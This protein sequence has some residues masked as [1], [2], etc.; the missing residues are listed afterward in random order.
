MTSQEIWIGLLS[1]LLVNIATGALTYLFTT[2]RDAAR[3]EKEK[4]E[5]DA[6]IAAIAVSQLRST[7]LSTTSLRRDVLGHATDVRTGTVKPE[8]F[9]EILAGIAR[10]L[11][12]DTIAILP[13]MQTWRGFVSE[14]SDTAKILDGMSALAQSDTV[15]GT[16]AGS[17]IQRAKAP[18]ESASPGAALPPVVGPVT[19][20][21]SESKSG[22]AAG[23]GATKRKRSLFTSPIELAAR[24][25]ATGDIQSLVEMKDAL[26]TIPMTP[27][28]KVAVGA[29]LAPMGDP[30][31]V[32]L[33]ESGYQ[34]DGDKFDADALN[35]VIGGLS[36]AAIRTDGE[37][38]MI[39]RIEPIIDR[40]M[41]SPKSTSKQKAFA[42][43]QMQRLKYSIKD[44]AGA[45]QLMDQV[46]ALN[47]LEAS[48][49]YNKAL[50]AK[51]LK[52]WPA[53][54]GAVRKMVELGT[55]DSDHLALAAT[56]MWERNDK[57][58]AEELLRKLED[59][60]PFM[61]QVTRDHLTNPNAD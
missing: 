39:P 25:V 44:V 22:S 16:S 54:E 30:Y 51:E 59:I 24:A 56:I 6:E 3:F 36:Q 2:K 55:N 58:R 21:R 7:L 8:V 17:M 43:N 32:E 5:R 18:E 19:A 12:Q 41:T 46:I 23:L 50:A 14:T 31:G 45:S 57:A 27:L 52:D 15:S 42:L 49:Q 60:D 10:S 38:A 4:R 37:S 53:A 35:L 48:Y 61:A 33:L 28:D 29:V 9:A 13:S 20:R 26:R 40:V 11:H 1:G 34:E 47:P